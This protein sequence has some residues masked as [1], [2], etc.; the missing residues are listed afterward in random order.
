M[1]PG[2]DASRALQRSQTGEIF[3]N[4]ESGSLLHASQ[5]R[6]ATPTEYCTITAN[7]K[8]TFHICNTQTTARSAGATLDSLFRRGRTESSEIAG[9]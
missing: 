3:L 6:A 9:D 7:G 2:I 1:A 8:E 5:I 4:S